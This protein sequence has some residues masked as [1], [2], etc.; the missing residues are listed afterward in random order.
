MAN[1]SWMNF[2]CVSSN[3]IFNFITNINTLVN[4][5]KIKIVADSNECELNLI[6]LKKL[7]QKFK[8]K[9]VILFITANDDNKFSIYWKSKDIKQLLLLKPYKESFLRNDKDL[10]EFVADFL[11]DSLKIGHLGE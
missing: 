9:S 4:V 6:N 11:A 5:I 1:E 2:Y 7:R 8:N 10:C 3:D